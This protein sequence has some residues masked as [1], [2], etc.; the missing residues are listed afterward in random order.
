MAKTDLLSL[1]RAGCTQPRKWSSMRE[2]SGIARPAAEANNFLK[3]RIRAR[4]N[5]AG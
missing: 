5:R 3:I 2:A 4:R 1:C